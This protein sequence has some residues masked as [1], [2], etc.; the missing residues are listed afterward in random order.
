VALGAALRR[1]VTR[2]RPKRSLYLHAHGR[3]DPGTLFL[4][5]DGS[6]WLPRSAEKVMERGAA[7]AGVAGQASPHRVRHGVAHEGITGAAT[8]SP[9]NGCWVT[10]T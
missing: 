10:R 3:E 1:E 2:F 8:P 7:R 5:A 4:G 6:P 9:L